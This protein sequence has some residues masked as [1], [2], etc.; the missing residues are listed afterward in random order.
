MV[1]GKWKA[2]ALVVGLFVLLG[3]GAVPKARATGTIFTGKNSGTEKLA[4]G[5]A[6]TLECSTSLLEGTVS[7]TEEAEEPSTLTLKPTASGCTFGG[8]PATVK[9][10]DCAYVLG[11]ETTA[12]NSDGGEHANLE[13]E[14]AGGSQIEIDTSVCTIT[15]GAQVVKHAIRYEADT[16]SSFKAKITAKKIKT[17]KVK[18]TESQTGCLL[19][20]TGEIGTQ[21]GTQTIECLEDANHA[22]QANPTTP[23]GTEE[24]AAVGC[25]FEGA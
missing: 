7:G 1:S 22:P 23:A 20:P 24:G 21:T 11:S 15:I 2:G 5:S 16:G 9:T 17:G 10:N 14:C 3:L 8:L 4:V 13:V 6:G 18:T 19:F 12:G 25:P